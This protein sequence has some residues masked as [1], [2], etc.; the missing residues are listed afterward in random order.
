MALFRRALIFLT[1]IFATHAAPTSVPVGRADTAFMAHS[2]VDRVTQ[3]ATPVLRA[4]ALSLLLQRPG[5]QFCAAPADEFLEQHRAALGSRGA[6]RWRSNSLLDTGAGIM[7]LGAYYIAAQVGDVS[8]NLLL[9][10]GSANLAVASEHCTGGSCP[11]SPMPLYK[12]PADGIVSAASASCAACA[13]GGGTDCAFGQP[14]STS[15]LDAKT[16][17]GACAYGISYGGGSSFIQGVLVHDRVQLGPYAVNGTVVAITRE[18]PAASFSTPPMQGI[19]GLAHELQAVNPTWAPTV[20][21][22]IA[23]DKGVK[24]LFGLCLNRTGGGMLDLGEVVPERYSGEIQYVAGTQKRWY[25]VALKS[26]VL[27]G[28]DIGLP[29][30]VYSYLNDQIGS[31]V[32]SG[33]SAFLLSPV[34]MDALQ[35][36]FQ[37]RH[38]TLPG[39]IG[40]TNMFTGA[41]I[42]DADM[43]NS[44][45][46][47]PKI[48]LVMSGADNGKD[49]TIFAGPKDYFS[50]QSGQYCFMVSAVPG[51]GAVIGDVFMQNYYIVHDRALGRIGF[52]DVGSCPGAP[53]ENKHS[54]VIV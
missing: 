33:T 25:N 4:E 14:Y 53:A 1:C 15:G 7:V 35:K 49:V 37:S 32:D 26:V 40:A 47:Y 41:C 19:I 34:A 12:A 16:F 6:S 2:D 29:S 38:A 27:D 50:H 52:A 21:G 23:K 9:D 20:F 51:V 39:V 11:K 48:G 44:I 22:Q 13:P 5:S 30:F 8:F 28:E 10:T 31:F 42:S 54:T 45:D 18:I 36:Q 46:K 3:L 17:P 24:D 43:G